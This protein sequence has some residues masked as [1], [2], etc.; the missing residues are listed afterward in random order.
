M[1]QEFL[2]RDSPAWS[3]EDSQRIPTVLEGFLRILKG[4]DDDDEQPPGSCPNPYG[5][6]FGQDEAMMSPQAQGGMLL[7]P[8]SG[9]GAYCADSDE[10][11][12]QMRGLATATPPSVFGAAARPCPALPALEL[13]RV[14]ERNAVIGFHMPRLPGRPPA[15]NFK[16]RVAS[17]DGVGDEELRKIAVKPGTDCAATDGCKVAACPNACC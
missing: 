6:A 5:Y 3:L 16:L 15:T 13:L 7:S 2:S 8:A 4:F 17:L 11:E 1:L 9:D 14:G 10:D 12:G